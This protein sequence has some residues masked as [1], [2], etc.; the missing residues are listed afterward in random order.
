MLSNIF[1]T[2]FKKQKALVFFC[3]TVEA[4]RCAACAPPCES[5]VL[6]CSMVHDIQLQ[7][8]LRLPGSWLNEVCMCCERRY[9]ALR[10]RARPSS[11]TRGR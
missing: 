3:G 2:F 7:D 1:F 9:L 5:S 6:G 4:D 10:R 8:S 11:G